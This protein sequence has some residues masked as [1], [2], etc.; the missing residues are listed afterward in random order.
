MRVC[1][2]ARVKLF[3]KQGRRIAHTHI[4]SNL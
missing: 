2:N 3:W 1:I 4:S